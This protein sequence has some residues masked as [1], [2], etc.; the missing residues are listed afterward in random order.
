MRWHA[1]LCRGRVSLSRETKEQYGKFLTKARLFA[2]TN[3]NAGLACVR[4]RGR[5]KV[6]IQAYLIAV[7]QNLNRQVC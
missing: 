5:S 6:Q 3:C 1:Q 2:E 7:T 4:Y